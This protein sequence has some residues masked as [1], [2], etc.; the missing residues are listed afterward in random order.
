MAPKDL[1][2]AQKAEADTLNNLGLIQDQA[3]KVLDD[4]NRMNSERI[5]QRYLSKLQLA[6]KE[7]KASVRAILAV[8]EDEDQKKALTGKL[9]KQLAGLDTLLVK[10][11]DAVK[12]IDSEDDTE[13]PVRINNNKRIFSYI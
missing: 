10:L 5:P 1:E 9:T 13:I 6:S 7:Y 2:K 11:H 3:T 12:T 4:S 8:L